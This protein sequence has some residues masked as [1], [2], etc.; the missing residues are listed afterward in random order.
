VQTGLRAR[1]CTLPRAVGCVNGAVIASRFQLVANH[2][3]CHN[4]DDV[5][6][7]AVIV[8]RF[9]PFTDVI[10]LLTLRNLP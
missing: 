4:T 9:H 7:A 2:E 6:H 3:L 10:K 8:S 1:R 5:T